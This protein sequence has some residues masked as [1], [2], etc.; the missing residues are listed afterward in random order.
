MLQSMGMQESD[1]TEQLTHAVIHSGLPWWLSGKESI[2]N[3]G[4]V[5]LISGPGDPRRKKWQ[6]TPVFLPGKSHGQRSMESYS[7]WLQ[8]SDTTEPQRQPTTTSHSFILQSY[9]LSSC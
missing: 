7:P 8:E 1:M 6:P 9:F 2:C 5:G 4:D 3:A